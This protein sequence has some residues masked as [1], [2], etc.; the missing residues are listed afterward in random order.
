MPLSSVEAVHVKLTEGV[1]V[2]VPAKFVGVVGG[3]SPP[4]GSELCH[5]EVV[6]SYQPSAFL[7]TPA[8]FC[9]GY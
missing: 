6:A 9:A 4:F 2:D 8:W 5:V 1:D 3:L 7:W